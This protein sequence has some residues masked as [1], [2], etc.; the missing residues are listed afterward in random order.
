MLEPKEE[1]EYSPLYG[2]HKNT[3]CSEQAVGTLDTYYLCLISCVGQS[4]DMNTNL[5]CCEHRAELEATQGWKI[6]GHRRNICIFGDCSEVL[7]VVH[8]TSKRRKHHVDF[9]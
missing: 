6:H 5:G 4:C 2:Q 9:L 8:D 7:S 3:K 1:L